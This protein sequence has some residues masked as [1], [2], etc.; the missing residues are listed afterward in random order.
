MSSKLYH[1]WWRQVGENKNDNEFDADAIKE[2]VESGLSVDELVE[3]YDMSK[4]TARRYIRK[5]KGLTNKRGKQPAF[6]V[7]QEELILE[8]FATGTKVAELI[9]TFKC[10]KGPIYRLIQRRKVTEN[11]IF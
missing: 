11:G 3:K 6:T 4:V 9:V 10:S 5:I 1:D 7:E 2:D 8:A